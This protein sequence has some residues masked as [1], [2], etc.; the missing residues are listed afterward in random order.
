VSYERYVKVTNGVSGTGTTY[1]TTDETDDAIALVTGGVDLVSVSYHAPHAPWHEPPAHLH[2]IAPITSDHDRARAMLQ[3]ADRELGRLL[4]VAL[5]LGYTV[6]VYMDNGTA[7]PLGGGKGTVYDTGVRVPCFAIGPGV[8]PGVDSTPCGV[9]DLYATVLELLEVDRTGPTFGPHSR[10]LVPL[11]EGRPDGRRWAYAERF[12]PNGLDPRTT[13]VAWR[14]A[15]RGE[16]YKLV[17]NQ[18]IPGDRLFDLWA[19]PVEHFDLLSAGALAPE[20]AGALAL[21]RDVL[22]RL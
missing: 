1:I 6:I 15:V 20:A 9:V 21:F 16:R 19:D 13:P 11:L 10:S 17:R 7:T 12:G 3:A 5:P 4:G 22:T 8:V 14:R 2:S 18:G